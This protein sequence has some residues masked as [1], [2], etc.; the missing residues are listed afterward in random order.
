M[1]GVWGV[2]AGAGRRCY[3]A[4]LCCWGLRHFYQRVLPQANC[5]PD[6]RQWGDASRCRVVGEHPDVYRRVLAMRQ[7]TDDNAV[8]PG[9]ITAGGALLLSGTMAG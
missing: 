7:T 3:G 4:L 6:D 8:L 9:A 1:C 2:F 5:T